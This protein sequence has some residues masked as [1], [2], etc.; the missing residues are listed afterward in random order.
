MINNLKSRK[1]N[2]EE[3]KRKYISNEMRGNIQKIIDIMQDVVMATR[4]PQK[5]YL[6][7]F[8]SDP[9]ARDGDYTRLALSVIK[10][11]KNAEYVADDLREIDELL[12]IFSGKFLDAIKNNNPKTAQISARALVNGIELRKSLYGKNNTEKQ[13][14]LAARLEYLKCYETYI[15]V[16]EIEDTAR[17][18]ANIATGDYNLATDEYNILQDEYK[19]KIETDPRVFAVM[20]EANNSGLSFLELRDKYPGALDFFDEATSLWIKQIE[21]YRL[22]KSAAG[23][24][25]HYEIFEANGR[26]IRD[27][28][29]LY[30]KKLTNPNIE[31]EI[32]EIRS[33]FQNKLKKMDIQFAKAIDDMA[34]S[35]EVLD[36]ISDETDMRVIQHGQEAIMK[37]FQEE[38]DDMGGITIE[39]GAKAREKIT[40]ELKKEEPIIVADTDFNFNF[41]EEINVQK[42]IQSNVIAADM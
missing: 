37:I 29:L 38:V 11:L 24:R 25:H 20:E 27:S 2:K 14:D 1:K 7:S 33:N 41:D 28:M 21:L 5:G 18:K 10:D 39:T 15:D 26:E 36:H 6:P 30:D 17:S 19:K 13:K 22:K 12:I 4:N 40:Q 23:L 34:A 16:S 35:R 9:N 3:A 32:K 31:D 42:E 8:K